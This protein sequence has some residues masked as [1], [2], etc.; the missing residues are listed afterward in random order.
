MAYSEEA[1][2]DGA[3]EEEAVAATFKILVLGSS[4]V[5]KTSLIQAYAT[6]KKP[7]SNHRPTLGEWVGWLFSNMAS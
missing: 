3:G 2:V 4:C 5:G 6:A 7:D 1:S